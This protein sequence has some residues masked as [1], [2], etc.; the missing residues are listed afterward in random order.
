VLEITDQEIMFTP[1]DAAQKI[2]DWIVPQIE[3]SDTV[4]EPFRG[5]GV[6]YD[7]IPNKKYYCEINEG[8]DFFNYN[9]KVDWAI[10][11]PPFQ[12]KS[13][14][15]FIPIVNRT[16]EICNKG[17]FYLINHKL[18]SSI[19]IKRL[20]EWKEKD[21]LISRI[22]IIEIKKWYGRYYI[23]KFQKNGS[24]VLDF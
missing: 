2:I 4:L 1:E 11:N 23:I 17:F 7:K 19:T 20:K 22:K 12:I 6:L 5:N 15:A 18:W 3:I 10:S 14:N 16:M 24:S 9:K 13:V 21:W 8:L